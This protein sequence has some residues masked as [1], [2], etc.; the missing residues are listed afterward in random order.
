MMNIRGMV[1]LLAC[2]GLVVMLSACGPAGGGGGTGTP[3]PG[4]T[5]GVIKTATT[6]SPGS[7][8]CHHRVSGVVEVKAALTVQAGTKVCFESG[9]G[10]YISETGSLNASG[11]ESSRIVFTGAS[12]TKGYWKG[13]AFES[14]NVDNKLVNV[15]IRFA[16]SD[17][18]FCCGF[19]VGSEDAL[20]A[21]VMGSYNKSAKVLITGTE[22]S[23]SGNYGLFAFENAKL[24]GFSK[25]KFVRNQKAAV[26]VFFG[27][28]GALDADTV[29]SGGADPNGNG[30]KLVRVIAPSQ[31]LAADLTLKKLDVPYGMGHGKAGSIFRAK[32]ILTIDAGTRLEFEANSGIL[33]EKEGR[34]VVAGVAGNRVTLTGRSPTKGFWK[35]VALLSLGNTVTQ[36]DIT[37][38]GGDD[39]FCCGFFQGAD[40]AKAGLVVGDYATAATVTV[41]DSAITHS[42]NRGVYRLHT[43]TITQVGTNDL[44]TENGAANIL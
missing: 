30:E 13:L 5:D 38:A 3:P 41:T 17:E 40:N 2:L 18:S 6:W 28:V 33:V 42:A 27:D 1:G 31:A 10:L 37:Y 39:P 29:Y 4:V 26:T 34:I 14:V 15:D 11:T 12:P 36:T 8:D 35:G 22:I 24:Q 7:G 16:G 19:F 23:D 20:A 9:A 43:S 32:A 44:T 25:N 21:V